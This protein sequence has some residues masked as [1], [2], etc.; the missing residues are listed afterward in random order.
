[1]AKY[2]EKWKITT[3]NI[4]SRCG[5]CNLTF[6]SWTCRGDHIAEHYRNDGS[7]MSDWKGD[8]GFEPA[9]ELLKLELEYFVRNFFE[10]NETLP[11]DN[12]LVYE[13]C[14][15]IFGSQFFSPDLTITA[16]SWVRDLFMS[17]TEMA[18]KARLRPMNQLTKLRMSQLKIK[19]K[20]DIFED[21]EPESQ[22]CRHL[23]EHMSLGLALSDVD[24]QQ[25][26]CAILY[27]IESSSTNPSRRF[28][29]FL[30]RLIWG[31][32]EWIVR[33]RQRAEQAIG[34]SYLDFGPNRIT[35]EALADDQLNGF[36]GGL[37][38]LGQL[39]GESEKLLAYIGDGE[40]TNSEVGIAS[41]L[42]PSIYS[43]PAGPEILG[44]RFVGDI[45]TASQDLYSRL[46]TSKTLFAGSGSSLRWSERP[47][48]TG[49]PFFLNDPNRYARLARELLRFVAST[50]SPNNPNKH[51]PTDE[52]IR[53]QARWILY[54]E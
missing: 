43:K 24:L 9:Y 23:R 2:A 47:R 25:E 45:S 46:Q 14:S 21:C 39:N 27:R 28:A 34:D 16:S 35:L 18:A 19:G 33:L 51:V 8:W 11:S 50:M 32:T 15:I 1:M 6:E 49:M 10:A 30:V 42:T 4:R 41:S 3:D 12:D 53:Y 17:S 20:A 40:R 48:G 38:E 44:D 26:A 22:L 37:A 31:S 13:G 29:G 7:T 54:D 5:F 36:Y 52:E